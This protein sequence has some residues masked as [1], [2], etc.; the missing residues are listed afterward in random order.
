MKTQKTW[1]MAL[2]VW[3]LAIT[4]FLL[5]S[6]AKAQNTNYYH[7]TVTE[8]NTGP[9]SG[10]IS[11]GSKIILHMTINLTSWDSS[12]LT[13]SDSNFDNEYDLFGNS[14]IG[15]GVIGLIVYGNAGATNFHH[16]IDY[17]LLGNEDI[18]A[19]FDP[20]SNLTVSVDGNNVYSVVMPS[21]GLVAPLTDYYVLLDD[22]AIGSFEAWIDADLPVATPT[23][24]VGNNFGNT[25]SVIGAKF[26]I[27]M[28][29]GVAVLFNFRSYADPKQKKELKNLIFS[30]FLLG[31]FI[32]VIAALF[33]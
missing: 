19:T 24:P 5:I 6:Q 33:V 32:G 1:T 3:L 10:P 18:I 9:L 27:L 11:V 29:F 31:A 28:G 8:T 22:G 26:I 14:A 30:F 7:A 12:Q 25:V 16:D 23:P 2:L 21:P 17:V 13:V 4:P 20:A 15:G